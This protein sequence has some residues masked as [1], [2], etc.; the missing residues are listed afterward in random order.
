MTEKPKWIRIKPRWWEFWVKP[1]DLPMTGQIGRLE[2]IRFINNE[3]LPKLSLWGRFTRRIRWI[4]YDLAN[5]IWPE[6][7]DDEET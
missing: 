4:Y 5:W 3:G 2:G 6:K 1:P 7:D